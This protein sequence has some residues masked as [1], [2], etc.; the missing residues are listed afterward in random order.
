MG[1]ASSIQGIDFVP[2]IVE[3]GPGSD[4]VPIIR[5]DSV[6]NVVEKR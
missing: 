6:I 3:L 1:G 5:V 4:M 2:S